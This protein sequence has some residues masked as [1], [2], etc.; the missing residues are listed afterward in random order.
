MPAAPDDPF[1]WVGA[2]ADGKYQ[3]EACVGEGGFGVV[4]RAKH[5]GFGEMVAFKCL[6]VPDDLSAEDRE[7]FFESFLH[8]GKLQHRLSRMTAGIVQALDVGA[9]SSPNGTWTP[10]LVLEWLVGKTLEEDMDE[11]HRLGLGG[12]PV[13]EA[14]A[15][16]DP[17]ARALELAH[18]QGVA[19]RDV[20]PANLFLAT[21][22]GRQTIKVLDFGIAKVITETASVSRAFEATGRT[23]QAFTAHYGAPEQFA[24]RFG[25]TGP[26]T[27]VFALALVFI[28]L[29][30]GRRALEGDD[31]AELFV[32]AA[33]VQ[34]RPTLRA[35]GVEASDE[36]ERVLVGALAV[37]PKERYRSMAEFWDALII[38]TGYVARSPMAS[39]H[40]A[41]IDLEPP[42]AAAA[43]S[44]LDLEKLMA[45]TFV[46][47][48]E[49]DAPP[50]EPKPVP[51]AVAPPPE[52]STQLSSTSQVAIEP[53]PGPVPPAPQRKAGLVVAVA[54]L[55]LAV[56]G[57]AGGVGYLWRKGSGAAPGPL[58][59]SAVV[60]PPAEAPAPSAAPPE[61]V[62]AP[63]P[64][65]VPAGLVPD[66]SVWLDEFKLQRLP[67][68]TGKSLLEAHAH[69]AESGLALCTEQQWARACAES[70]DLG[71]DP[72]WTAS[73]QA[74]GFVVRGGGSCSA[75]AL[76]P[77][78]SAAPDRHGI[79]CERS[80]AIESSN[81][82]KTFVIA[83]ARHLAKIEQALNSR[84]PAAFL[85]LVNEGTTIDGEPKTL[86]QMA[87]DFD[88][89][90]QAHPDMWMRFDTCSVSM[91]PK[92]H[93]PLPGRKG[94]KKPRPATSSAW[95]AECEVVRQRGGD[96][97]LVTQ[98]LL[99]GGNGRL[100][101]IEDS[102]T[103][104]AWSKP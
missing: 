93:S 35:R 15:L 17:V 2:T 65:A 19:H 71:R 7:R 77:P 38:A 43:A 6:R 95:S 66:T 3:I 26:W 83:T 63:L 21:I 61:L 41:V 12:R 39:A 86:A 20:K 58:P 89:A 47:G 60:A 79:C 99:I 104:R 23:L 29:V 75:R 52:A 16:L 64:R 48:S 50:P 85:S 51:A 1:G 96:L 92:V 101:S 68:D 62:P 34:H 46:P 56:G 13:H 69:C 87:K 98:S 42:R 45:P 97:S 33:D 25:A 84:R 73:G 31:A 55:S 82:N 11:R 4:Y 94:K 44:D 5:L 59:P 90:R 80:V 27:D 88:D 40:A 102:R 49:P 54:A 14:I 81:S 22:G 24:R 67:R 37:D 70:P 72:T 10:Y 28:E 30:S 57:A 36:V 8:E 76:A 78:E 100:M 91:K 9:C 53:A 103:T 18:E 32:S 74:G